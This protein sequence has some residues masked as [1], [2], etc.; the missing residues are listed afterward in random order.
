MMRICT[1]A[2]AAMGGD[3]LPEMANAI[4]AGGWDIEVD[5]TT[6]EEWMIWSSTGPLAEYLRGA[7]SGRVLRLDVAAMAA[8]AA[9]TWT[10][11]DLD[12]PLPIL[13]GTA[14]RSLITYLVM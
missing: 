8:A 4:V 1:T 7:L 11:G 9:M 12:D 14:L 13:E 2:V 5:I 10:F 3:L 6:D